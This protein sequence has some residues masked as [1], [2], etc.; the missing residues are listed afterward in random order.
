MQMRR[1]FASLRWNSKLPA[2]VITPDA[3][4]VDSGEFS[5]LLVSWPILCKVSRCVYTQWSPVLVLLCTWAC[6]LAGKVNCF[7]S[8]SPLNI[9]FDSSVPVIIF[10]T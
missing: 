8:L 2:R 4:T 10:M 7:H 1:L 9:F 5:N 3:G 6:L